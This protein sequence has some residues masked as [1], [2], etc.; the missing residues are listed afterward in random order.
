MWIY[1]D[2]DERGTAEAPGTEIVVA[3]R[4]PP[5]T[6]RRSDRCPAVAGAVAVTGCGKDRCDRERG[7]GEET[8]DH[9]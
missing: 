1:P 7:N 6:G 8:R 5:V 9:I 3:R 2:G 4:C